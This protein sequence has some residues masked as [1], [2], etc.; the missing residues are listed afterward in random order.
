MSSGLCDCFLLRR[1]GAATTAT[2]ATA[3]TSRGPS[4]GR[5]SKAHS[6]EALMSQ[7]LVYRE[8]SVNSLSDHLAEPASEPK[9]ELFVPDFTP[10][11]TSSLLIE[12]SHSSKTL[13]KSN[14]K[15]KNTNI[16]KEM[17]TR[18]SFLLQRPDSS[19]GDQNM[20]SEN[21]LEVPERSGRPTP[22]EAQEWGRSL[23]ALL[24]HHNQPG[25]PDARGHHSQPGSSHHVLLQRCPEASLQPDGEG[26]LPEVLEVA[27]VPGPDWFGA[28]IRGCV[29]RLSEHSKARLGPG[30]SVGGMLAESRSLYLYRA[31]YEERRLNDTARLEMVT[32]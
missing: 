28:E 15:K 27:D 17:K 1:H 16:A 11:Q 26:L 3:A 12:S 29:P 31:V 2:G 19:S 6:Q 25:L 30:P 20:E 5:E 21:S 13:E 18:L 22:H 4:G 8:I 24:S 14:E 7:D 10:F 23:E 32:S 9:Q